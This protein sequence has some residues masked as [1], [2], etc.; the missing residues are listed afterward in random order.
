MGKVACG[1]GKGTMQSEGSYGQFEGVRARPLAELLQCPPAVGNLLNASAQTI[2]LEDG[3]VVFRQSEACRGLYV[4]IS[5][6]FLR[7]TERLE[8]RLTLGPVRAGDVVELAA[9][10]GDGQHTYTLTTQEPGSVLLLPLA[11]LRRAFDLF[12]PLRMQLLEELAREVSRGYGASF[13]SRIAS[14]RRRSAAVAG[15]HSGDPRLSGPTS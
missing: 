2:E 6:L 1:Q 15:R 7:R 9:A 3:R 4:I 12:P 8:A 5:G 10:L 11:D 14:V 13:H